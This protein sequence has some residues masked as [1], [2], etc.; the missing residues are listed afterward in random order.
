MPTGVSSQNPSL[1]DTVPG[2]KRVTVKESDEAYINRPNIDGAKFL[3]NG[4][5]REWSGEIQTVESPIF[6]EGTDEKVYS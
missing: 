3:I 5:I 1:A 4:E 6:L 2:N